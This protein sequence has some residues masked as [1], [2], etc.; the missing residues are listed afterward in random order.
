M[1]GLKVEEGGR[2]KEGETG[3][4]E[5]IKINN[6][7]KGLERWV[8]KR[9]REERKKNIVIKGLEAKKGRRREAVEEILETIGVKAEVKEVKRVGNRIVEGREMVM[10]RLAKEEQKKEILRKKNNLK[11]RKEIV[12]E[13]WT[14]AERRM[15]WKIGEVARQEEERETECG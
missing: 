9:K 13:D 2:K 11:G 14:W 1:M 3:R 4:A 15:R 6:K 12:C 8:E 5:K 10:V 7:I